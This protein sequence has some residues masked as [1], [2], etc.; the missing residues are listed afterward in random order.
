MDPQFRAMTPIDDESDGEEDHT[1][2]DEL[3]WLM[4]DPDE[5][6]EESEESMD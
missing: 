6:Y 4:E 5:E 1:R 2:E 3:A